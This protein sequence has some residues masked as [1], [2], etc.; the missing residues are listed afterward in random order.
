MERL[1]IKKEYPAQRCEICHQA[2]CFDP[3]ANVCTRCQSVQGVYGVGVEGGQHLKQVDYFQREERL[4]NLKCDESC[5]N[6]LLMKMYSESP[7]VFE[8]DLIFQH[9]GVMVAGGGM[10]PSSAG[11]F[12]PLWVN[13]WKRVI[14]PVRESPT[15]LVSV[16]N[17]KHTDDGI[18]LTA[19]AW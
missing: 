15:K 9:H 14:R 11:S 5:S 4:D 17:H 7:P 18:E 6:R 8:V 19:K 2:D 10:F 12:Q 3:V 16:P 13:G 1:Q